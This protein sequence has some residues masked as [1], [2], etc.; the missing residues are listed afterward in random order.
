MLLI[1]LSGYGTRGTEL[2][3]RSIEGVWIDVH[4]TYGFYFF[5][6]ET[7]GFTP[8][9]EGDFEGGFGFQGRYP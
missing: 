1:D 3:A 9:L 5:I 7:A 4:R 8:W 6:G 2:G